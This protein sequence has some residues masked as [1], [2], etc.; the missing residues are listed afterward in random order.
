MKKYHVITDAI[1]NIPSFKRKMDQTLTHSSKT[2]ALGLF[3]M[4][5]LKESEKIIN[6]FYSLKETIIILLIDYQKSICYIYKA[7]EELNEVKSKL[8]P[9]VEKLYELTLKEDF[10][11][12]KIEDLRDLMKLKSFQNVMAN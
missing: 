7:K 9:Y 4:D 2:L 8:L 6:M 5:E 3:S 10:V 12:E 11:L 1:L